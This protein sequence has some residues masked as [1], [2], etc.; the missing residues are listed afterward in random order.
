MVGRQDA[1]RDLDN[2]FRRVEMDGERPVC[3][4]VSRFSASRPNKVRTGHPISRGNSCRLKIGR[5]TRVLTILP[6]FVLSQVSEA[7]L[8]APTFPCQV[9]IA[10]SNRRLF[11][12]VLL[13]GLRSE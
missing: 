3:P 13:G 9:E 2:M 1:W 12:S 7:R 4:Q 10:R 8:G 6:G 11:D 5:A